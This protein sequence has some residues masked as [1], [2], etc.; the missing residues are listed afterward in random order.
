MVRSFY[1][2]IRIASGKFAVAFGR[3]TH[4]SRPI[5]EPAVLD[6]VGG[7]I[8]IAFAARRR[9]VQILLHPSLGPYLNGYAR[10]RGYAR[11]R[12]STA[13]AIIA[14]RAGK[15]E[16]YGKHKACRECNFTELLS[17]CVPPL[18]NGVKGIFW[19]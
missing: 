4:R 3:K 1:S 12:A 5:V 14:R 15:G 7:V 11:A 6:A 19:K 17:H 16:C 9:N 8:A 10:G 2:T 13:A 18:V